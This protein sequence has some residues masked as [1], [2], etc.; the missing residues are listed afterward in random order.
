M[1]IIARTKVLSQVLRQTLEALRAA[2][3]EPPAAHPED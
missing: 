3:P 1:P 2:W